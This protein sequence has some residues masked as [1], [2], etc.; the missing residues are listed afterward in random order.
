VDEG[1]QPPGGFTI[2]TAGLLSAVG[3][4]AHETSVGADADD[5]QERPARFGAVMP[6]FDDKRNAGN[7]YVLYKALAHTPPRPD[8]LAEGETDRLRANLVV[9]LPMPPPPELGEGGASTDEN[10]HLSEE[11][12]LTISRWISGGTPCE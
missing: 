8:T 1:K 6:L 7:S 9:G 11:Q 4:T 10:P 2:D 5:A 12:L 3:R